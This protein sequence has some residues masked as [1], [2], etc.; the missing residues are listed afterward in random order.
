MKKQFLFVLW[1]VVRDTLSDTCKLILRHS[2]IHLHCAPPCSQEPWEGGE[3]G[4]IMV[5]KQLIESHVCVCILYGHK[6][7]N[8]SGNMHGGVGYI[9]LGRSIN[10]SIFGCDVHVCSVCVCVCTQILKELNQL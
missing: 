1:N 8:L 6:C 3:A 10:M 2:L 4:Y 9:Y 7:L 5:I